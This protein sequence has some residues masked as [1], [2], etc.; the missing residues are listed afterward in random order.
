MSD[1]SCVW[2][3]TVG[4]I[5]G[6]KKPL[7]PAHRF[8]N[9]YMPDKKAIER[10]CWRVKRSR[11]RPRADLPSPFAS[12]A[13]AS[14]QRGDSCIRERRKV[15]ATARI[16]RCAKKRSEE[17]TSELQSPMRSSY[18]VLSLKKKKN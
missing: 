4:R 1:I 10:M 9:R 16:A 11:Q 7:V 17:H 8:Q 15:S 18:A 14:S 13:C 3:P 6:K 5:E 2:L 12:A